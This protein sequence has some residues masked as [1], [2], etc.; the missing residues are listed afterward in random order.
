MAQLRL[1]ELYT[2]RASEA[3]R[4][5]QM[6]A[7]ATPGRF[8]VVAPIAAGTGPLLRPLDSGYRGADY[9]FIQAT[10]RPDPDGEREIEYAL[11]TR[12]A[13]TEVRAQVTQARLI[14]NL[15]RE[16]SAG[17]SLDPQIGSTLY[18][19]LV[20]VELEA[21]LA[22]S[23]ETHMA[24]DEG[25]A[26]IP[27][28]LL[29]DGGGTDSSELPWAIRVEAAAQ[30]QDRDVSLAGQGRRQPRARSSS[31][32]SRRARRDY[33]PLPGAHLEA[34]AVVRLSVGRRPRRGLT[35]REGDGR[36]A[37]REP[38][39]IAR[40]VVNAL[41]ADELAR[42]SMS[43]A[44]ARCREGERPGR[45]R[46]LRRHVPRPA[47]DRRDARRS[48][49]GVHQLLSSRRAS[50]ADALLYDRVG[51]ASGVAR[52]LIDL[53]VRCVVAA[54]WAVDDAAAGE[55]AT[56]FYQ[57]LLRGERF[58]DAVARARAGGARVRRQHLG[59]VSVLW[60]SGLATGPR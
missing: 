18:K 49:A 48:R 23:G 45:R 9:D 1:V 42:S 46:A 43:P 26:G 56:T 27:W 25:T 11:D 16:A 8:T 55:F 53:G 7:D 35:G 59:G 3:W 12:R 30:I 14:R 58:I 10:T 34:K 54:G 2:D 17:Q 31:S 24:L 36:A 51:F 57:S 44:T 38:G 40:T 13:R 52:T 4:A 21:F 29:D 5:L 39:P 22:G 47:G 28:E 37:R 32:A 15:V 33:P 19:L 41:L 20:P 50:R 6:Q 60:R